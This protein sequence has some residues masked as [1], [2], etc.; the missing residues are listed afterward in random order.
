MSTSDERGRVAKE[1]NL[2]HEEQVKMAKDLKEKGKSN[3][4]IAFIMRLPESIIRTWVPPE[5]Q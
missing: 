1:H 3:A 2:T 5:T 4:D